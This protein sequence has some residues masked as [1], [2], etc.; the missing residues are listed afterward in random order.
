MGLADDMENSDAEIGNLAA[1]RFKNEWDEVLLCDCCRT[2]L[3]SVAAEEGAE[4]FPPAAIRRGADKLVYFIGA[5]AGLIKIGSSANPGARL[6][7]LQTGHP[8][9]LSVMATVVGGVDLEREYHRRFFVHHSR[10]EWF[11]RHPDILAEIE[12]ISR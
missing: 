9:R 10:G 8:E 11:E 5:D 2:R 12:R 6:K 1:S 3:A 7:E 4:L